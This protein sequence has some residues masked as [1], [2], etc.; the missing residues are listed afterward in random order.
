[1]NNIDYDHAFSISQQ[2]SQKLAFIAVG[3]A[4]EERLDDEQ[5]NKRHRLT[6]K[7]WERLC[8]FF[9]VPNEQMDR[10]LNFNF[11]GSL[12]RAH[13]D[14]V[15]KFVQTCAHKRVLDVLMMD[16]DMP[17]EER[18]YVLHQALEN[19][20][21]EPLWK[22]KQSIFSK[23]YTCVFDE[24]HFRVVITDFV[25]KHLSVGNQLLSSKQSSQVHQPTKVVKRSSRTSS[26]GPM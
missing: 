5:C 23:N 12:T 9:V 7:Q 22:S 18:T 14:N 8:T 13:Q 17:F 11:E 24:E 25:E 6:S 10:K 20:P 4:V 2:W 1:M 15:I 21:T 16:H 19:M 26:T 3:Y